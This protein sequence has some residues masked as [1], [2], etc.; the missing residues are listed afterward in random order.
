MMAA[1]KFLLPIAVVSAFR[2]LQWV[3]GSVFQP[4]GVHP[5]PAEECPESCSSMFSKL[6]EG[7]DGEV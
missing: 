5:L 1:T 7:Q 3:G 2:L 4:K 6:E